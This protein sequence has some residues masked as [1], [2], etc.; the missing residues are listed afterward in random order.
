ML[1]GQHVLLVAIS[2]AVAVALGVPL[3]I[4]AARRPRLAAP[5]VGVANAVQTVPSLAM[6]GFLLPVPLV[7][8]VGARAALVVLV[9]YALLP[10]VRATIVGVAGVDRSVREAGVAMGMT[11]RQLLRLVELP[12]ALPS[13]VSG[14]RVAAVVG[15]RVGHHCRGDRRGRAR[16]VHLSRPVDGRYDRH[17]RRGD[18]GR[19]P[20]PARRWR[21]AVARTAAVASGSAALA[22][23]GAAG[24]RIDC[25]PGAGGQR[26]PDRPLVGRHRRGVEELHRAARPG[27]DR[28]ADDRARDRAVRPAAAESGR[29][30][31]LRSRP[32]RRRGR[33]LRRVHRHRVDRH[34]PA[35]AVDRSRRRHAHGAAALRRQRPHAAAAAR[36]RQH[37]RH[38]G[39]RQGC[40]GAGAADD[41]GCGT[42][43]AA[44]ARR[45]RL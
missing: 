25:R 33:R 21:P 17:P 19:A 38:P 6:F 22:S 42:R 39:A 8:G 32:A 5:L 27:R 14:V 4:F 41:R 7:G 37:V 34:L 44:M 31:D 40:A 20:R 15:R 2:T 35:P 26:G 28:G 9:L 18:S 43:D 12:L 29:H 1:V 45:L 24:G 11:A 23:L 30:A 10:I 13:I 36:L 16:P 3:G